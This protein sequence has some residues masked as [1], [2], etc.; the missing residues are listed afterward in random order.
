MDTGDVFKVLTFS[1]I[2]SPLLL[3]TPIMASCCFQD[4]AHCGAVRGQT[5][6]TAKRIKHTHTKSKLLRCSQAKELGT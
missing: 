5:L 1:H 4:F 3:P 6:G 2:L